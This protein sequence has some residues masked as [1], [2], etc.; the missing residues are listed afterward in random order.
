MSLLRV[1]ALPLLEGARLV[2]Q[3]RRA[4]AEGGLDVGARVCD[5][6]LREVDAIGPHIR[7]QR[8]LGAA[9]GD[10]FVEPLGDPHH[11]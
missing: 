4:A 6:V 5:R 9:D 10:A 3:P 11:V 8:D 2:G 1:R 7:D